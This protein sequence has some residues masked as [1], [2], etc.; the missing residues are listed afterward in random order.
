V[1]PT[2]VQGA[3]D[4]DSLGLGPGF[5]PTTPGAPETAGGLSP[6][7][8]ISGAG[9]QGLDPNSQYGIMWAKGKFGQQ[10][11]MYWKLPKATAAG[12]KWRGLRGEVLD[13]RSIDPDGYYGYT[14][15]T[16]STKE[17]GRLVDIE[18]EKIREGERPQKQAEAAHAAQQRRWRALGGA[19]ASRQAT[20]GTILTSPAGIPGTATGSI[21]GGTTLL[22]EG[23]RL[24]V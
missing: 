3:L 15:P 12:D 21:F 18:R 4:W 7:Y 10:V 8:R 19:V 5:L 16:D 2:T 22:G 14:I 13:S 17:F 20:R 1:T 23:D 11:Q 24:G 6:S 9:V